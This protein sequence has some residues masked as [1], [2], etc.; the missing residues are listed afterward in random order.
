MGKDSGKMSLL[1]CISWVV[2][3]NDDN[4]AQNSSDFFEGVVV[5]NIF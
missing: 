5:H 4:E 2:V 3:P 1:S